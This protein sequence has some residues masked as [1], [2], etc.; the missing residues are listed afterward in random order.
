MEDLSKLALENDCELKQIAAKIIGS[1]FP[2]IPEKNGAWKYL[3][4]VTK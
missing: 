4:A 3:G 1:I 2:Y